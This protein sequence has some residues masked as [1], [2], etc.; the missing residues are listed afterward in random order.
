MTTLGF[1]QPLYILPFDHRGSFLENVLGWHGKLPPEQTAEIA[2][3]K[4]VIYDAFLKAVHTGVPRDKA[5]IL[6]DEQF[7][8]AILREAA[9]G[10]YFSACPVE[11][12]GQDE[13][14]FE[15]GDRF[16]EH[17]EA[18]DPTF[19]KVLVRYH[20][21][22]DRE[23]NR[24]QEARL[25]SLSDYLHRSKS[26]TRFM[27]ELLVPPPKGRSSDGS[28]AT[29]RLTTWHCGRTSW[30]RPS[31]RYRTP[32]WSRMS[33]RSRAWSAVP[34]AR[35]SWLPRAGR[36]V[37]RWA[38]SSWGGAR[39]TRRCANGSASRQPFPGSLA[40]PWAGPVSGTRW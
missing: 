34:I 35:T 6:V 17:I 30:R 12:S 14:D 24:R 40:S 29:K 26:R 13:F 39:T 33:G 37:I 25:K 2:G 3:A 4:R 1:N 15:Y 5:G 7:G 8:A 20:P 22:G 36:G 9:A 28:T 32:E 18:L 38:A 23:L 10:G 11:K 16:A 27:F 21:E 31:G 19:C